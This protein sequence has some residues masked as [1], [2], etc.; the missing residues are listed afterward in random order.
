VVRAPG[1]TGDVLLVDDGVTVYRHRP[2]ATRSGR[3]HAAG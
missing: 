1:G 2:A 3:R